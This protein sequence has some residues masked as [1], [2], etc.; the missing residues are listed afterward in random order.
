MT[1]VLVHGGKID[2]IEILYGTVM[3][4]VCA[5]IQYKSVFFLFLIR[6]QIIQM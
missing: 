1:H 4:Y 5:R 3:C 2:E 6:F